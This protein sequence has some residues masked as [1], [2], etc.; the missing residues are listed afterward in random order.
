MDFLILVPSVLLHFLILIS[1][2]TKKASSA[3]YK[4]ILGFSASNPG[5]ILLL[6]TD[7]LGDAVITT[8]LIKALKDFNP[9]LKIYILASTKNQMIFKNNPYIEDVFSIKVDSWLKYKKITYSSPGFF[10]SFF[11]EQLFD[12][13]FWKA[14]IQ[15]KRQNIDLSLDLVGRKRTS[16]FGKIIGKYCIT[17]QLGD[18]SYL[19]DYCLEFPF[20]SPN[21]RK[22][23]IE[24]YFYLASKGIKNMEKVDPFNYGL[25]LYICKE[26]PIEKRDSILFHIGGTANRRL[27]NDRLLNIIKGT[28]KKVDNRI[29]IIDEPG[30]PNLEFFKDNLSNYKIN[31]IENMDLQTLI[32]FTAGEIFL[33]F[34]A[35]SGIAHIFNAITNTFVYYGQTAVWVWYPWDTSKPQ[36]V[37]TYDNGVHVWQTKGKYLHRFI[38][39]PISCSPCYEV[40]CEELY[41]LQPLEPEFFVEQINGMIH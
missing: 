20:V 39:Y 40:G 8:P 2:A 4:K 1:S 29:Y 32:E 34:V 26:T 10:A 28:S 12:I 23:I 6:R 31:F 37:K 19:A 13:K 38:F 17:H 9:S 35:D 21:P 15:L 11:K 25:E 3:I 5:R 24:R 22:H 18:F 41:C 27:N 36:H 14:L 30:N 33:A 7:R 16:F